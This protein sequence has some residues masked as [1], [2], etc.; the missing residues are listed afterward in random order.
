[1]LAEFQTQLKLLET[2]LWVPLDLLVFSDLKTVALQTLVS[3]GIYAE[4]FSN[5]C[6]IIFRFG[7]FYVKA[8]HP[9]DSYKI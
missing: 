1:M 5:I 6:E 4:L 7:W 9:Y 8:N 3:A 2:G